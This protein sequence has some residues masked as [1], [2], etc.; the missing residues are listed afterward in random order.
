MKRPRIDWIHPLRLTYAEHTQ[1]RK[2]TFAGKGGYL[3]EV[4]ITNAIGGFQVS[5]AWAVADVPMPDGYK[6]PVA[7][8]GF[9][10]KSFAR[11]CAQVRSDIRRH[12]G[13]LGE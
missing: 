4:R 2:P 1:S 5:Y 11:T 13:W 10:H 7:R 9:T 3:I 8:T 12:L 6:L